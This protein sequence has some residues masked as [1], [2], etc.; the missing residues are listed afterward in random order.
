MTPQA[1]GRLGEAATINES[2]RSVRGNMPNDDL[3]VAYRYEPDSSKKFALRVDM[4]MGVAV[5]SVLRKAISIPRS[6]RFLLHRHRLRLI[7]LP[8]LR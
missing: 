7:P 1:M 5:R 8:A 4:Q 2:T 3:T 6:R